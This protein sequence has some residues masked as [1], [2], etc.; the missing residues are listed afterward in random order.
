MMTPVKNESDCPLVGV[1]VITWNQREDTL[2][3]LESVFRMAYP[4]FFVVLV[5]NASTDGT[6]EAVAA[7]FPQ[8]GYIANEA[9]R[10]F[11]AAVNQGIECAL[12]QGAD[13]LFLLNNDTV[14]D[15]RLLDHLMEYA[16]DES[17]GM[18][19]PKIYY[20]KQPQVIW[21]VGAGLNRWTLEKKGEVRGCVDD[22]RWEKVVEREHVTACAVLLPRRLIEKIGLLDERFFYYY[23]D[24][25]LSL[26]VREAGYTTLLVP[27]AKLW[28][29]VARASGGPDTTY[30]RYW[31]GRSSVLFFR[32]HVHGWRWLIVAPYR[33][34]SAIKTTLRL[35]VQRKFAALASYWRGLRDGLADQP[36]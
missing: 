33:F 29:K 35:A 27:Q 31:M 19:V 16:R 6:R 2:E 8:V 4:H 24:A 12:Q 13:Y 21:S 3:C 15:A 17:V 26:R 18:L 9:N 11:S 25:D 28:H 1:V 23:D 34:G 30:E 7:R 22:G 5:D 10:G 36:R 32:K 14:L 20:H